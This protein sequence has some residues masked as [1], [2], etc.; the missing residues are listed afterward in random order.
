MS[1]IG[2]YYWGI[3]LGPEYW[4]ILLGL[5]IGTFGRRSNT[6]YMI[7]GTNY[8]DIWQIEKPWVLGG[9][10][11]VSSDVPCDA[12]TLSYVRLINGDM[13]GR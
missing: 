8:W 1:I 11:N 4:D 5:I 9:G 2:T 10:I 6:R 3:L 12:N 13:R 7:I